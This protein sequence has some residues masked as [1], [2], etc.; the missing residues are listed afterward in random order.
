MPKPKGFCALQGSGISVMMGRCVVDVMAG[1]NKSNR[2]SPPLMWAFRSAAEARDSRQKPVPQ[3]DRDGQRLVA[4]R[5][6]ASASSITEPVLRREVWRDLEQLLNT[7]AL[8]STV[9]D[10]RK[11]DHVR[12]SI[13][14]FGLPDMAHRSIDEL[15][16]N[17]KLIERD[18]MFALKSFEPRLIAGS[19]GVKRDTTLDPVGLKVRYIITADLSCRPVDIP[20]EFT[21]EVDLDSGR[22]AINRL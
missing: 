9:K 19:V 21:A 4:G 11:I 5:K 3:D 8:E 14:N 2:L 13:L 20:L 16:A 18:I 6:G 10:V 17:D 15:L 7:V 22:F 1:F 12:R